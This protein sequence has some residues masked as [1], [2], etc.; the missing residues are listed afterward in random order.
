MK[1][2]IALYRRLIDFYGVHTRHCTG[3]R[4]EV[5]TPFVEPFV[6][7]DGDYV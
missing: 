1:R 7:D 6:D 4:V 5:Y 2:C 3:D